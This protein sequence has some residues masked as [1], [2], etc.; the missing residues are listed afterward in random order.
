[1][2][3]VEIRRHMSALL[4]DPDEAVHEAVRQALHRAR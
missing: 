4:H 1:M 3:G 2:E